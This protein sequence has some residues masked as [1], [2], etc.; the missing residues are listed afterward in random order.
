MAFSAIRGIS[1]SGLTSGSFPQHDDLGDALGMVAHPLQI[2][3]NVQY[4]DDLTQIGRHRL[5]A[6]DKIDAFFLDL[7]SPLVDEDIVGDD[8][9][10]VR[11]IALSCSASTE[12]LMA[13]ITICPS[14]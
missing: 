6:G 12:R 7:P 5:L 1:T 3:D 9:L 4:R 2:G 10:G 11:G 14:R 8:L 13:V